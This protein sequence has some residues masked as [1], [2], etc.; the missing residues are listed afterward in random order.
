MERLLFGSLHASKWMLRSV[1]VRLRYYTVGEDIEYFSESL[2]KSKLL[3]SRFY[4]AQKCE[5][6]I[7]K[8]K[9]KIKVNF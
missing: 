4:V 5:N 3:V 2:P 7:K 9:L 6:Y 8:G 1:G